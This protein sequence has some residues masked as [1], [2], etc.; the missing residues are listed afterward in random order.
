MY[1]V[2]VTE[3]IAVAH[4]LP[5]VPVCERLHGHNLKIE[6][7]VESLHCN[8]QNM[9]VDFR[10]IKDTIKELDHQYLNDIDGLNMPTAE[11]IAEYLYR[12]LEKDVHPAKVSFIRIW[13]SEK[14]YVEFRV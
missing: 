4:K 6:V 9:V 5:G 10:I 8:S 11:T 14:A 7:M 2:N 3:T 1:S 13:E 12:K